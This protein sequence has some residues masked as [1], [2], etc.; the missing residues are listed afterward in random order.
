MIEPRPKCGQNSV[1]PTSDSGALLR[2]FGQEPQFGSA[3]PADERTGSGAFC[4]PSL[5][6]SGGAFAQ[7]VYC[8]R[9]PGPTAEATLIVTLALVRLVKRLT[10]TVRVSIS[11]TPVQLIVPTSAQT[12]A[13]CSNFATHLTIRRSALSS[14]FAGRESF[15]ASRTI[16][17]AESTSSLGRVAFQSSGNMFPRLEPLPGL[18]WF[19]PRRGPWSLR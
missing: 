17:R 8:R 15:R 12:A 1:R 10:I 7:V 5:P 13:W 16:G 4:E 3:S 6:F 19:G 14:R 2:F 9:N 18:M 11:S